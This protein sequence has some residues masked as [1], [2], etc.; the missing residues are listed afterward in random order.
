MAEHEKNIV[1]LFGERNKIPAD[2]IK[3][4]IAFVEFC[5]KPEVMKTYNNLRDNRANL[6]REY[7]IATNFIGREFNKKDNWAIYTEYMNLRNVIDILD[8]NHSTFIRYETLKLTIESIAKENNIKM[9]I[10]HIALSDKISETKEINSC[11]YNFSR[12]SPIQWVRN[13]KYK[14]AWTSP[15]ESRLVVMNS[16]L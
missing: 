7:E 6:A 14:S 12:K 5:M 9:D 16:K 1:N 4:L 3:D 10:L 13:A 8:E 11:W 2:E 15:N